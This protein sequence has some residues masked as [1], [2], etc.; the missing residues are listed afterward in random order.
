MNSAVRFNRL[1]FLATALLASRAQAQTA[2]AREE[3]RQYQV[4]VRQKPVGTVSIRIQELQDG[5]MH[6][7][8]D[9]LV[10]AE[11]FL[12]KHRYEYHGQETWRGDRLTQLE[13]HTNDNGKLLAV[14]SILDSDRSTVKLKDQSPQVGPAFVMTSNYW[15]L[16]DAKWT[17]GKFT[18]IDSD[19]GTP[20][21]VKLTTIGADTLVV[22]NRTIACQH[23]R[24]SGDTAAELW[25]DQ[26]GRL[27]RQQTVEQGFATEVRLTRT[28]ISSSAQ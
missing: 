20:L 13:S 10:E 12:M 7:I 19:T 25:F 24:I 16:P 15:R 6:S 11:F 23:Y 5:S 2:P 3:V 14:S 9:T 4:L 22:E 17:K 18:I 8:T 21:A 28:K 27:V 1:F 26:Q